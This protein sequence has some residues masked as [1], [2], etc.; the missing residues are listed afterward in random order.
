MKKFLIFCL[1]NLMIFGAHATT[2]CAA[3]DTLAIVL[4]P[5]VSGT[6]H[7]YNTELFEWNTTFPYGTVFGI[8]TCIG[9]PS[10]SATDTLIDTETGDVAT[11]GE[12][13]GKYCWCQMTHPVKS[14][15]VFRDAYSSVA[16][17]RSICAF[18]CGHY[19]RYHT[20][21]RGSVFGS[22]GN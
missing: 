11:G 13:T 10:G 19:V 20:S 5:Q 8:A 2:M 18:N 1:M 16:E 7:S 17:C 9:T 14:R 12:R 22:V 3:D 6:N 4:D 15:W 21:F